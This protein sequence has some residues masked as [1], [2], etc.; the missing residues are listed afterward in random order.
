MVQQDSLDLGRGPAGAMQKIGRANG[1][2]SEQMRAC[3]QDRDYAEA[4]VERYKETAAADGIESTPS[5][6]INGEVVQ[7][8]MA[9]E[10]FA[11]ILDKHLAE[12]S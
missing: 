12:A 9:Y 11:A 10:E 7:G 1:L 3:L 2:S 5:F 4:L 8:N 6:V